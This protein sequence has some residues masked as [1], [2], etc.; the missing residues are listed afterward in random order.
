M[1]AP[2]LVS[3]ALTLTWSPAALAAG[4]APSS[5][6][7]AQKKEA[8]SLFEKGMAEFEARRFEAAITRFSASHD[9]VASPNSLLMVARSYNEL[10][11]HA[12]A[13]DAFAQAET[14]AKA[15]AAGDKKYEEALASARAEKDETAKK[16]AFVQL[17]IDDSLGATKLTIGSREIAKE[18]WAAAIAVDP[19]SAS[20]VLTT[21]GDA[22]K[23]D[24]TLRAGVTESVSFSSPS[25]H[26]G[27]APK[28]SGKKRLN[29]KTLAYV[30]GGAGVLGLG[31]FVAEGTDTGIGTGGLVL[32]IAG[33]G[34][35]AVLFLTASDAPPDQPKAALVL[36]PRGVG[37]VGSF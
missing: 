4:A 8:T 12:E 16:V 30:A 15:A 17:T 21:A 24:V 20:L 31:L 6:S 11:R 27:D 18:R 32:A 7:A 36:G 1:R 28:P 10:G 2:L 37:L 19:G 35:G 25:V 14:E 22:Q 13:Y 5:A 34:G 9:V 33:L 3:L 23:K 29:Q 26:G